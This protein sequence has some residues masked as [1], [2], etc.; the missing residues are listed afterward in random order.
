MR[1]QVANRNVGLI[2]GS[3]VVGIA[4]VLMAPGK[5]PNVPEV[6]LVG[7]KALI[8]GG[9]LVVD[10]RELDVSAGSH[11]VGA[12]LIP[13]STLPQRM[14]ELGIDQAKSIV[15]YCNE[16]TARGPEGTSVLQ[17]AGYSGAVN[18][19]TGIEGWRAAG[20]PTASN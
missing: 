16:G 1:A 8:D 12:L 5:R 9:A 15:V 20:L 3:F 4:L 6:D 10:V 14:Q 19:K 2:L 7:A 13:L 18:L 17:Q 11:I